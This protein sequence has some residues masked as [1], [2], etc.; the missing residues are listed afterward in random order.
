MPRFLLMIPL[1]LTIA[2]GGGSGEE[3]TAGAA[4]NSTASAPETR[5]VD[6]TQVGSIQGVVG[7]LGDAPTPSILSLSADAWCK[8]HHDTPPADESLLIQ[9]GKLQNAFVWIESGLE[10]FAFDTPSEKKLLDQV[11]CIFGPRV[12]GVQVG[13]ALTAR[14]SDPVLHNV[15]SKPN[16]NRGRNIALPRS[17]SERDFVF[18]KPEVMIPI[19]CDVH[20][21]MRAYIGVVAH[22]HFVVTGEDGRFRLEG[23]PAG[24]LTLA[25][26]HETLGIQ[27]VELTLAAGQTLELPPV[28]FAVQ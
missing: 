11:G 26:W 18:D 14:N 21:W 25:V 5:P 10:G 17:G 15:H 1:L 3:A 23:V 4:G 28:E 19:I 12:T 22:P 27:R 9:D 6:P 20:P 24:D 2:C 8:K 7:A 13:Q 16:E